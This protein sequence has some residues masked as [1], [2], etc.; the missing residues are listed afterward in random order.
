[1]TNEADTATPTKQSPLKL[2]NEQKIKS[3]LEEKIPGIVITHIIKAPEFG[4][5]MY[6]VLTDDF[7]SIYVNADVRN[8]IIGE[9]YTFDNKGKVRN[10]S[11]QHR[12]REQFAKVKQIPLDQM[13][14]FP[15]TD[16]R[17]NEIKSDKW[18]I[19]FTDIDCGYCRKF[20]TEIDEVNRLG[21]EVRYMF[22]PRTGINSDAYNKAVS[23]WCADDKQASMTAAKA[24]LPIKAKECSNPVEEQYKLGRQTGVKGTPTMWTSNGILIPGYIKPQQLLSAIQS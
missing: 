24:G 4:A 21:I 20:H 18:V 8:F 15:A 10:L 12:A 5:A 13:I 23:V 22:F 19:I 9:H 17:G 7:T 11:Q 2:T 14:I 1:M 16:N 6:H 3:I